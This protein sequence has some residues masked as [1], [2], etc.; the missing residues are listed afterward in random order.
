MQYD[1]S[2]QITLE[3]TPER[4]YRPGDTIESL[5]QTRFENCVQKYT[6]MPMKVP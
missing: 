3:Q 6:P 5:R 4:Y 1:L 2:S